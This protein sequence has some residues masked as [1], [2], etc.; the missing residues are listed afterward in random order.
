MLPQFNKISQQ[1]GTDAAVHGLEQLE[2]GLKRDVFSLSCVKFIAAMPLP[3]LAICQRPT[4]INDCH[5][6]S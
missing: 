4:H 1:I 3:R 2:N 5:K 6:A